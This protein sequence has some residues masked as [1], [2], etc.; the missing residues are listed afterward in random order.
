MGFKPL[1][2]TVGLHHQHYIKSADHIAKAAK[3]IEVKKSN[4]DTSM[5]RMSEGIERNKIKEAG[6][7]VP[8]PI[9]QLAE[10]RATK[11]QANM[12]TQSVGQQ[13]TM[14]KPSN[15]TQS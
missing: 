14:A 8:P 10:K 1:A 7:A 2:H 3:P 11:M 15:A 12:S 6:S 9:I 4:Y 13:P 5:I